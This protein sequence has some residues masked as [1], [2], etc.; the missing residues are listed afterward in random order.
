MMLGL[1]HYR[2]PGDT[3]EEFV[4]WAAGAGFEC[5]ELR[6]ADLEPEGVED[7]VANTKALKALL[8]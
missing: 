5:V 4:R 2:A 1:I 6:C 8:D 7:T 3:T